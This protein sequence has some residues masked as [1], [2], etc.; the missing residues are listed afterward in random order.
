MQDLILPKS[1]QIYPN[2]KHSFPNLPN[3]VQILPKKF[4]GCAAASPAPTALRRKV[5]VIKIH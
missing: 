2:L 1:N 4:L 5:E 3:S